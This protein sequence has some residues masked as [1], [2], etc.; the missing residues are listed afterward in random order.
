MKII[1]DE[2][3]NYPYECACLGTLA[4]DGGGRHHVGF[5]SVDAE[6]QSH[7]LHAHA[8]SAVRELDVSANLSL[9]IACT[10]S[11]EV[12]LVGTHQGD[13]AL[14]SV[15]T[16]HEALIYLVRNLYLYVHIILIFM[17]FI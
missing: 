15:A 10:P 5:L 17:F 2:M 13:S 14:H 4:D 7:V 8:R 9:A 6:V 3:P 11:I 12:A 1:V 16:C